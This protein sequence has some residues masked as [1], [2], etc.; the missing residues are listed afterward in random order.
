MELSITL[1]TN[2]KSFITLNLFDLLGREAAMRVNGEV[3][4]GVHE[5]VF[6]ESSSRCIA[7]SGGIVLPRTQFV[8]FFAIEIDTGAAINCYIAI[9]IFVLMKL[10]REVILDTTVE[11]KYITH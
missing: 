3:E 5:I 2:P 4:P 9:S 1:I 7:S 8:K 10:F 6:A 11:L